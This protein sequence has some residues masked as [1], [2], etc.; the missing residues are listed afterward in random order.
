MHIS[1][2]GREPADLAA[3]ATPLPQN[4]PAQPT[5]THTRGDP[6]VG[7]AASNLPTDLLAASVRERFEAS[8]RG[9]AEDREGYA[10][11][12]DESFP[13]HDVSAAEA[14]RR[15]ALA[16]DFGWLPQVR[17]VDSARL[18]RANAAYV[19]AEQTVYLNRD[20]SGDVDALDGAFAEEVG[21]HL[22][23]ILGPREPRTD[24][25]VRWSHG[26]L[27]STS[28]PTAPLAE[29]ATTV[30]GALEAGSGAAADA[31]TGAYDR[32]G[33]ALASTA[34]EAGS[35]AWQFTSTVGNGLWGITGG[36]IAALLSDGFGA[37]WDRF[38][39]GVDA[40]L[41]RGPEKG[42]SLALD[43]SERL[44]E[45]A[46][47][48]L[49]A[50]WMRDAIGGLRARVLDATRSLLLGSFGALSGAARNLGEAISN[51]SRGA[52]LVRRGEGEAGY[53]R[54]F[55]ALVA[56]PQTLLD[57][58]LMAGGKALSAVQTLTFLEAPGRRLDAHEQT[59]LRRVFADSVDLDQV[60]VKEGRAGLFSLTDR[61]F[62][63]GNTIYMK[64][65]VDSPATAERDFM[66]VLVGEVTHVW[67]YQNGGTDYMSESLYSQAFGQG[68]EWARDAGNVPWTELEPEQQ[69]A[70]LNYAARA[71]AFD[72][73]PPAFPADASV[74][75]GMT[76]TTLNAYLMD[77]LSAIHSRQG[78][79]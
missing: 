45:S 13:G 42:L 4:V 40:V 34:S 67:Q 6:L 44:A 18:D 72:S 3:T 68:Y 10:S 16:G 52:E 21:R 8:F 76:L 55:D 20:R 30:G 48:L 31:L 25:A 5:A 74:P 17:F 54:A 36:A 22:D 47:Q 46:E 53:S 49:P 61:P 14:L 23:A 7:A 27:G 71:G 50:S 77:S 35:G 11:L 64:S 37:A 38:W 63:L 12:L 28:G 1:L 9:L 70:F 24:G 59:T 56:V 43:V 73:T 65:L 51:L 19:E 32:A 79:P 60:R 33:S 2:S 62:V 41:F 66:H 57:A 29:A 15:R 69:D 39:G 58:G 26:L 75:E 78:A